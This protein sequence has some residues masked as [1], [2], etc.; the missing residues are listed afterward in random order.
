MAFASS[1]LVG[2]GL[3][4]A[5]LPSWPRATPRHI[6]LTSYRPTFSCTAAIH[7]NFQSEI[8]SRICASLGRPQFSTTANWWKAKPSLKSDRPSWPAKSWLTG[9]VNFLA[10]VRLLIR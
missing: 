8:W 4:R 10:I 3:L 7:V 5:V 2:S 9:K 1:T 6:D